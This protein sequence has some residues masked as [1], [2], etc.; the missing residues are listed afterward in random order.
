MGKDA[1]TD[2]PFI[3]NAMHGGTMNAA[4][5]RVHRYME[6]YK[7]QDAS[8]TISARCKSEGDSLVKRL[9]CGGSGGGAEAAIARAARSGDLDNLEGKGRPL[10]ERL[11]PIGSTSGGGDG[12]LD[13]IM[14]HLQAE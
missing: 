12:N 2:N 9:L 3:A 13:H 6:E 8:R 5:S 4:D 7:K 1:A 10:S 14:Y 11:V